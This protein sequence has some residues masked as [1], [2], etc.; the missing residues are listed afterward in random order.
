MH[1]KR[2]NSQKKQKYKY[3]KTRKKS[4]KP[5]VANQ[6]RKKKPVNIVLLFSTV[7]VRRALSHTLPESVN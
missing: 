2:D 1:N 5:L 4:E 6:I 3:L 7:E